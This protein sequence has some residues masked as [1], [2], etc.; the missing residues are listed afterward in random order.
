MNAHDLRSLAALATHA[1]DCLD[2]GQ[3][4]TH[5]APPTPWV[6]LGDWLL[7]PPR[8]QAPVIAIPRSG[9]PVRYTRTDG[10]LFDG[11]VCVESADFCGWRLE[12]PEM[13]TSDAVNSL[14]YIPED[15]IGVT[16]PYNLA[17]RVLR[18]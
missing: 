17:R 6:E 15:K 1:A 4:R 18:I 12:A 8:V 3:W 14:S 10:A 9:A 5:T 7:L 2:S 13:F 11:R 16:I